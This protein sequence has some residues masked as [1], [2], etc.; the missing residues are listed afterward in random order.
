MV[1]RGADLRLLLKPTQS[2]LF[3][4]DLVITS[5]RVCLVLIEIETLFSILFKLI[6]LVYVAILICT[7]ATVCDADLIIIIII[8]PLT[9]FF[10][11]P[12]CCS[13]QGPCMYDLEGMA[14]HRYGL[15]LLSVLEPVLY[16]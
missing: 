8:S 13:C 1:Y 14:K 7:S 6:F 5:L 10:V 11:V 4:H 12:L 3:L 15:I 9:Y 2:Y 16:H